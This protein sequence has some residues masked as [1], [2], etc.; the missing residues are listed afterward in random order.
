MMLPKRPSGTLAAPP[1]GSAAALQPMRRCGQPGGGGCPWPSV[2]G[3]R[4]R[5]P[6]RSPPAPGPTTGNISTSAWAA[7]TIST[8]RPTAT[9]G[10]T[11]RPAT[12]ARGTTARRRAEKRAAPVEPPSLHHREWGAEAAGLTVASPKSGGRRRLRKLRTDEPAKVGSRGFNII[13]PKALRRA[14]RVPSPEPR[15]PLGTFRRPPAFKPGRNGRPSA[16]G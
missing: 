9:I 1:P 11:A 5:G 2:G 16:I 3:A 8:R 13:F 4:R 15:V 14:P 7:T 12:E 6:R 10:K